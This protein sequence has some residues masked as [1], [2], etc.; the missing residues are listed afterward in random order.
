[1]T[2]PFAFGQSEP[3][4]GRL[5]GE[6][7]GARLTMHAAVCIADLDRFLTGPAHP[8]DLGG[9][10]DVPGMGDAIPA[11]R[12]VF[13]LFSPEGTPGLKL[14]VYEMGFSHD[15]RPY[16]L[17]GRKEVRDDPGLDLWTDTTTLFTRL[18]QGGDVQGPAI[19]AGVIG[20][21]VAALVQLLGTMEVTGEAGTAERA[22][23]LTRFGRM[24]L[25]ELWDTYGFHLRRG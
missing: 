22:E 16:Y 25:G 20:L 17:A 2:G 6:R 14:M 24:F 1:M 4:A 18:Y 5:A 9:T 21:G 11:T 13:N 23:A 19:G 15:G 8:G 7:L 3:E 12:G 10:L